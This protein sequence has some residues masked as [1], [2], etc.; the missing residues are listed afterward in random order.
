[1]YLASCLLIDPVKQKE[2]FP[3]IFQLRS[4][5]AFC[6]QIANKF[7]KD[8]PWKKARCLYL[9]WKSYITSSYSYE[10]LPNKRFKVE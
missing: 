7:L 9:W 10:N 4:G 1:M 6:Y 2:I 3:Y 8:P 5:L